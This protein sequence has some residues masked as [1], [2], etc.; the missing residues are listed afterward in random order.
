MHASAGVETKNT[1]GLSYKWT[2]SIKKSLI[3]RNGGNNTW[4]VKW[5]FTRSPDGGGLDTTIENITLL[6]K[7]PRN[8]AIGNIRIAGAGSRQYRFWPDF[9]VKIFDRLN[10]QKSPRLKTFVDEGFTMPLNG[11]Q[12][13]I[14]LAQKL[15]PY[16]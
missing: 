10:L 16:L 11:G 13:V 5:T 7:K 12:E 1:F 3:R 8:A 14:W 6:L 2:F 15:V 9:L 4:S